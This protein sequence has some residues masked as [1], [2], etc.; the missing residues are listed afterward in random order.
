MS[1]VLLLVLVLVLVLVNGFFV[2]AEFAIVRSRRERMEQ[3][4]NDGSRRAV[5]ALNQMDHV[6]D[7]VATSQVGITLASIGLG[8]AGEPAIAQLIEPALD[9]AVGHGVATALSFALAYTIV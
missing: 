2:A 7:Y 9:G 6:D 1:A 4:A 3:L 8:F 5:S